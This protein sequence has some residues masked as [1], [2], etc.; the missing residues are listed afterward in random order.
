VLPL[1]QDTKDPAK[2]ELG[3]A[4]ANRRLR[5]RKPAIVWYLPGAERA[6]PLRGASR[7]VRRRVFETAGSEVG[8]LDPALVHVP[9]HPFRRKHG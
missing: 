1:R 2:P 9:R 4:K 3:G 6:R 5:V 8:V 7:G